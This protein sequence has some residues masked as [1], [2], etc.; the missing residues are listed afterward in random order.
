[1]SKS[2]LSLLQCFV[3]RINSNRSRERKRP[4]FALLPKVGI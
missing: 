4:S 3:E 2:D 1:M